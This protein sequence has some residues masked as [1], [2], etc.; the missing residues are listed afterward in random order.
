MQ[1]CGIS[2]LAGGFGPGYVNVI[3]H[4]SVL[5]KDALAPQPFAGI[6][7][8][9]HAAA[10]PHTVLVRDHVDWLARTRRPSGVQMRRCVRVHGVSVCTLVPLAVSIQHDAIVRR[11]VYLFVRRI[12]VVLEDRHCAV[13]SHTLVPHSDMR[14]EKTLFA[15]RQAAARY[16]ARVMRDVDDRS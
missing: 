14:K 13:A 9:P 4:R 11:P 5:S 16:H 3:R 10:S 6:P 1:F 7:I 8:V 12:H 2:I 15:T